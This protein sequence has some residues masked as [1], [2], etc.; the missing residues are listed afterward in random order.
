ME[1]EIWK[2]ILGGL[3]YYQIS[4]FG[5]IRSIDR[6]IMDSRGKKL[7]LKGRNMKWNKGAPA[8]DGYITLTLFR[9]SSIPQKSIK[10]HIE[11]AKA[12]LENTQNKREVNH[13]D[14]NKSNNHV[15]NLEWSTR[16][17]NMK[18][19]VDT[20]LIDTR[21]EKCGMAKLK[22]IEVISIRKRF[23]DGGVSKSELGRRYGVTPKAIEH[24]INRET[25]KHI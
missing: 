4:N 14:G 16:K 17:E 2:D 20:G 19:A 3:G 10:C 9:R 8:N 21:G 25:W 5:N 11:V 6:I 15:S 1:N 24:I 13:K 23:S 12:F 7:R 22:D 18:H